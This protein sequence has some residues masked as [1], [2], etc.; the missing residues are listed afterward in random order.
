MREFEIEES[1]KQI[2]GYR[3]SIYCEKGEEEKLEHYIKR[4]NL[5][6][7]SSIETLCL[8]FLGHTEVKIW[9]H[10]LSVEEERHELKRIVEGYFN[11]FRVIPM[12]FRRARFFLPQQTQ[13]ARASWHD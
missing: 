4:L 1:G 5:P 8:E 12:H 10:I 2:G 3:I 9:L 13:M 6:Y 7:L 11:R